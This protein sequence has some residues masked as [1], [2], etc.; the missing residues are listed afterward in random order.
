MNP[1]TIVLWISNIVLLG[2]VFWLI[3]VL[4]EVTGVLKKIS[5]DHKELAEKYC[6]AVQGWG[7]AN[8]RVDALI[9]IIRAYKDK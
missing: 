4:D 9:K 2:M 1:S 6:A 3:K 5:N 8:Y 7:E